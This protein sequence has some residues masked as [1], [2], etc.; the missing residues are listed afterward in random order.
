MRNI[1]EQMIDKAVTKCRSKG[2]PLPY[3]I[4]LSSANG[5]VEVARLADDGHPPEPLLKIDPPGDVAEAPFAVLVVD[6]EGDKWRFTFS[7]AGKLTIH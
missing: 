6:A 2:R 5:G 4:L 3:V 1:F 7:D